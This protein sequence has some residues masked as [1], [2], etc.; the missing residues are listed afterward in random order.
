VIERELYHFKRCSEYDLFVTS[1]E[2]L[3]IEGHYPKFP[4]WKSQKLVDPEAYQYLRLHKPELIE[5]YKI[6]SFLDLGSYEGP[7]LNT[8]TCKLPYLPAK[9][10]AEALYKGVQKFAKDQPTNYDRVAYDAAVQ[11][12]W[13]E[14]HP[15]MSMSKPC[16]FEEACA[17]LDLT[18]SPGAAWRA[19]FETKRAMLQS[20]RGKSILC[21][22][23]ALCGE[24]PFTYWGGLL[25][26]ELR[27]AEKVFANK[28]RVFTSSSF[29]HGVAL[30]AW[31]KDMNEKFYASHLQT[32]ST[33]G[34]SKFGLGFH[35]FAQKLKQHPNCFCLDGENYDG[36]IFVEMM[37][38]IRDFRFGC[39]ASEYQTRSNKEEFDGLYGEV[40][41][42]HIILQDGNVVC[43]HTGNPSGS[44]NTIVD[45][46][47]GLYVFLAY[48]WIRSTGSF[49]KE[50]FDEN[51]AL[52]LCG[53]DNTFSVSDTYVS[54]FNAEVVIKFAAELGLVMTTDCLKPRK[55]MQ[56]DYL[57]HN[58]KKVGR[59][60]VGILP[61]DKLFCSWLCG[62][63]SLEEDILISRSCMLRIEGWFTPGWREFIEPY[64][65]HLKLR[66]PPNNKKRKDAWQSYLT[67][68]EIEILYFGEYEGHV[69]PCP[70]EAEEF[71]KPVGLL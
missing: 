4:R 64:L 62:G 57:S 9:L 48:C 17:Y 52:L 2:N 47:L 50:K 63:E 37:R 38:D 65:E 41:D 3:S 22:Y 55:W 14:F 10:N 23:W 61:F 33:V 35:H 66:L 45:N 69:P 53:D 56:C 70:Y 1:K 18:K 36:S 15:H 30:T 71:L 34:T 24:D 40:I 44:V 6:D 31:C 58:F 51:V 13:E 19:S 42:S 8:H 26:D 39:L 12:M 20:M 49:D 11:W 28:T 43:K 7:K 59:Y 25:K 46:T 60:V 68:R 16:S 5:L 32:A 27:P 29:E 54:K 67:S 21:H